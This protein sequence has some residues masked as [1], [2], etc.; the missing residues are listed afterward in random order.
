VFE[1]PDLSFAIFTIWAWPSEDFFQG[2]PK[3]SM[4]GKKQ[5]IGLKNTLKYY[6]PQQS[7]KH[8]I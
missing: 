7:G 4:K 1:T 2:K 5:T 8:T 3:F 6:V